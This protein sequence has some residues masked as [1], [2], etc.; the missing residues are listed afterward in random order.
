[1]RKLLAALSP[2]LAVAGFAV[3]F[4]SCFWVA[5]QEEAR[6]RREWNEGQR[7]TCS[8]FCAARGG[9]NHIAREKT[10]SGVRSTCVCRDGSQVPL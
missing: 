8:E 6:Q 4:G 2:Y 5:T 7:A 9:W 1:M 10:F 3:L